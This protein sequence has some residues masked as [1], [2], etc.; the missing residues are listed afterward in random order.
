MPN[1]RPIAPREKATV[2]EEG[3]SEGQTQGGLGELS[4]NHTKIF[5]YGGMK[6]VGGLGWRQLE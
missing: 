2:R 3:R 5:Q 4:P 1:P 6:C